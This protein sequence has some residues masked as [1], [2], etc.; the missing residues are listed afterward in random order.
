LFK[1]VVPK[2]EPEV[3]PHNIKPLLELIARHESRGNYNIVYGGT[4]LDLVNKTVTQIFGVQRDMLRRGLHS[5][6]VG[7][8]QIISRT[9]ESLESKLK[10]TGSE[11][12]N[13]EL[14]DR[15]AIELLNRRQLQKFLNGTITLEQFALN[16]SKEWASLPKDAS[17]KSY[18]DGDGLNKAL[19]DYA[20]VVKVLRSLYNK[21]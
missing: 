6:A 9:L 21:E 19:V 18:Y 5:T 2:E 16:L 20:E 10:L 1:R 4:E 15:M 7:R 8:Y 3:K 17:N 13:E 14:Q 12:F 11:L